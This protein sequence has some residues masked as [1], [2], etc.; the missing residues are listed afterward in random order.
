[1]NTLYFNGQEIWS[2][3]SMPTERE[4]QEML[5]KYA[6]STRGSRGFLEA[7]ENITIGLT[8][9]TVDGVFRWKL[10]EDVL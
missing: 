6:P 8:V 3:A 7:S 9:I 1:M 2:G 5:L 4:A 10:T